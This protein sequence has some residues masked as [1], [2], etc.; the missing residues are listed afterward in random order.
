[1]VYD[2]YLISKKLKTLFKMLQVISKAASRMPRNKNVFERGFQALLLANNAAT[3]GAFPGFLQEHEKFDSLELDDLQIEGIIEIFEEFKDNLGIEACKLKRGLFKVKRKPSE[4]AL[5][6]KEK[7]K[8]YK[9]KYPNL[10]FA[11]LVGKISKA[12]KKHKEAQAAT[13]QQ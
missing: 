10:T 12:W 3:M 5:F 7:S 2:D 13:P 11:E 9:E 1:L 8:K 4:Y 6:M